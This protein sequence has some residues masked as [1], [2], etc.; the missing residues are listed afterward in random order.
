MCGAAR[1][2][3]CANKKR[4][5]VRRRGVL[6]CTQGYTLTPL[7]LLPSKALRP[8]LTQPLRAPPSQTGP[9]L[10]A[11]RRASP[12][13]RAFR[14]RLPW[15]SRVPATDQLPFRFVGPP[16]QRRRP[17]G[18]RQPRGATALACLL[19]ATF[20]RFTLR[21]PWLRRHC[22]MPLH[23]FGLHLLAEDPSSPAPR[24]VF[25]SGGALSGVST[26]D[27]FPSGGADLHPR[28]PSGFRS[29]QPASS[30]PPIA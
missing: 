16:P 10:P 30:R 25:P 28:S 5:Q 18:L 2:S 23:G 22:H 15:P 3:L 26:A 24:G 7:C 17:F 12:P 14:L 4:R 27:R 19:P 11:V 20:A 8:R 6:A 9:L 21:V 29:P 13:R 1:L